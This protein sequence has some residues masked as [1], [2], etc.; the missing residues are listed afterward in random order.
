LTA[1]SGAIAV[2]LLFL[3]DEDAARP[4]MRQFPTPKPETPNPRRALPGA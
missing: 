2:A 4:G 3:V 1:D